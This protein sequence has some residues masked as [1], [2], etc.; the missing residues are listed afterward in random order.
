MVRKYPQFGQLAPQTPWRFGEAGICSRSLKWSAS[1]QLLRHYS[2]VEHSS[3]QRCHKPLIT[4]EMHSEHQFSKYIFIKTRAV[5]DSYFHTVRA[6]PELNIILWNQVSSQDQE[7]FLSAGSQ[8]GVTQLPCKT[9]CKPCHTIPTYH[10]DCQLSQC[11]CCQP[12]WGFG[13]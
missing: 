5:S 7:T 10:G 13:Q 1:L 4:S 3:S 11:H 9:V 2:A 6:N 8:W 12:R